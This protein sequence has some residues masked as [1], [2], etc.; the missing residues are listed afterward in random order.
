MI[1]SR[2]R[3][4]SCLVVFSVV[5]LGCGE[6][7]QED[8]IPPQ[9]RCAEEGYKTYLSGAIEG[10]DDISLDAANRQDTTGDILRQEIRIHLGTA[11]PPGADSAQT[12]ILRLFDPHSESR[13]FAT[14]LDN[15]T[16]EGPLELDV[17]D[18]SDI[19]AGS[20]DLTSLEDFGCA[21]EDDATICAQIGFDATQ[22]E[23]LGDEDE[24]V[25]NAS[26]GT[27][28]IEGFNSSDRTFAAH[29]DLE[30]GRNVL[31]YGDE[32]SGQAQ[33]CLRA[34]YNSDDWSLE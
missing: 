10:D 18:A 33:G 21:I 24:L 26:G 7:E 14:Y 13:T 25:Y 22:N 30:L 32:S 28:T 23:L 16:S 8:P 29:W 31:R 12:I 4:L 20:S 11:R 3:L 5:G 1:T 19:G 9:Q 6:P 17:F 34:N 15:W 27:V 2:R